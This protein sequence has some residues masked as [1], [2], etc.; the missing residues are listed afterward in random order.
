MTKLVKKDCNTGA[1]ESIAPE[2]TFEAV[3]D[4]VTGETLKEVQNADNHMYL[5]FI[6]NSRSKTRLQVP[7]ERRRK[8]LWITYV[9]CQ[10]K[11]T[12][13]W[14][15]GNSVDDTSWGDSNNWV[16]YLQESVIK[17]IVDNLLSWYK[18]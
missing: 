13:E 12:S 10:G 17:E 9:S 14:Y 15:N 6:E 4:P 11:V 8:G 7:S 2:T 16:S 1:Y 18:V 5:P 3:V